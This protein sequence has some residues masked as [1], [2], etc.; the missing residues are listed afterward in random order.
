[1]E[2]EDLRKYLPYLA[3]IGSIG[4]AL[5]LLPRPPAPEVQITSIEV[6]TP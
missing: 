6:A 1:M 2:L 3:L 5:L 4:I